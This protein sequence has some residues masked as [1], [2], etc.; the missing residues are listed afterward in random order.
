MIAQQITQHDRR[1]AVETAQSVLVAGGIPD[2]GLGDVVRLESN[3]VRVVAETSRIRKSE[4]R[5]R[6]QYRYC[7]RFDFACLRLA[8]CQLVRWPRSGGSAIDRRLN[9]RCGKLLRRVRVDRRDRKST[10]L[11][12]SHLVISYAVFCLKKRNVAYASAS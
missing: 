11:N 9:S 1:A 8:R 7:R 2:L 3:R 6:V 12:S 4:I 5:I 10:R